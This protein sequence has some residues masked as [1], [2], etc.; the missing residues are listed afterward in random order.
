MTH[1][2]VCASPVRSDFF[3]PSAA[4][5]HLMAAL[6][7][8]AGADTDTLLYRIATTLETCIGSSHV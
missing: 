1:L 5:A 2:N 4:L 7:G 8:L 3:T 6:T